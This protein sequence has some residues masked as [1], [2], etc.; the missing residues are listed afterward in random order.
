[1]AGRARGGRCYLSSRMMP[2]LSRLVRLSSSVFLLS[3]RGSF[4]IPC[5]KGGE[6][7][8]WP[9]GEDTRRGETTREDLSR[10]TRDNQVGRTEERKKERRD[11]RVD[12][13][14]GPVTKK[15][16]G[17]GSRRGKGGTGGH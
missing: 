2:S 4:F 9:E 14:S 7:H 3:F 8:R 13:A 5:L 1:M 12:E 6:E 10:E 15:G 11:E 17:N 16:R